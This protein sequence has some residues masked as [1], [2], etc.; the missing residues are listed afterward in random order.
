MIW[1]RLRIKVAPDETDLGI[2]E[3]SI[4]RAFVVYVNGFELLKA[5]RFR[6]YVPYDTSPP[7]IAKLAAKQIATGSFVLVARVHLDAED[8]K[9]SGPGLAPENLQLGRYRELVE[10][11]SN[12]TTRTDG[13]RC[14]DVFLFALSGAT[15]L[16]L[17]SAE[18]SRK[19][20]LW[21][22][23]YALSGALRELGPVLAAIYV[24]PANRLRFDI[25]FDSGISGSLFQCIS[26]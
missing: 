19:E 2:E 1:Y 11:R 5:G 22:S 25:V 6:P 15:G 26:P 21:L 4:S 24:H 23:L 16:V 14:I 7:L 9:N 17:Y 8:W 20:Y 10:H 18:R 3:S 13:L 12:R